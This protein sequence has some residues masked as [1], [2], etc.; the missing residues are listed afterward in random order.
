MSRTRKGKGPA[1]DY[2]PRHRLRPH[3]TSSRQ[4]SRGVGSTNSRILRQ[5]PGM[6]GSLNL[7][8]TDCIRG[9]DGG[10]RRC[11]APRRSRQP[12]FIA[13]RALRAESRPR[14]AAIGQAAV[15]HRRFRRRDR[16]YASGSSPSRARSQRTSKRVTQKGGDGRRFAPSSAR[17]AGKGCAAASGNRAAQLLAPRHAGHTATEVRAAA[18]VDRQIARSWISDR[19]AV[20]PVLQRGPHRAK[21]L[22]APAAA[23]ARPVRSPGLLGPRR[24]ARRVFR[25]SAARRGHLV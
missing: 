2:R 20:R 16:R 5:G 22:G 11:G 4:R 18:Q 14:P 15:A 9:I 6:G 24:R 7:S 13:A 12:S 23:C 25:A 19:E 8:E 21:R 10:P 17:A 3:Q 1:A